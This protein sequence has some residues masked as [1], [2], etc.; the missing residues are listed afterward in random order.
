VP[1]WRSAL[2]LD[3]MHGP[4]GATLSHQYSGGYTE[5]V[6]GSEVLREVDAWSSWDLQWRYTGF[7]NWQLAAGI[8]NLFDADPPVSL[9]GNVQQTGYNPQV[10]S[11][12]GRT[13]YLRASVAFQQL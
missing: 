3:W 1:R 6:P 9:R 5:S 10:A 2:S 12:L 7:E 13:F 11:P 8:R 4:W